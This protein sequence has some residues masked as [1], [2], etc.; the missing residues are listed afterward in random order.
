M[1]DKNEDEEKDPSIKEDLKDESGFYGKDVIVGV[2][3]ATK[4]AGHG[5]VNA[6]T[7][8]KKVKD[9]KD[10]VAEHTE[11]IIDGMKE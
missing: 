7:R 8:R 1:T 5:F 10:E 11:E 9:F 2:V 4:R 3:D 6:L